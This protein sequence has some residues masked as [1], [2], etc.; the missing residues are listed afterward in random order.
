MLMKIIRVEDTK[1]KEAW[2][3]FQKVYERAHNLPW[4]I[5]ETKRCVI[6]ELS[7]EDLPALFELYAHPEVTRF[8]EPL[9]EWEK[10]KE[11]QEK[12]MIH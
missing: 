5:L 6:R 3:F 2:L 9:F 4:T 7:M 8:M 12:Y 1:N 10:E 11:Y